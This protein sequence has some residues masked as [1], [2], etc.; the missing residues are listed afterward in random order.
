[1]NPLERAHEQIRQSGIRLGRSLHN[2]RLRRVRGL[3]ANRL[4]FLGYVNLFRM[5]PV[6]TVDEAL[7]YWTRQRDWQR[8]L[9]GDWKFDAGQYRAASERVV[10]CRYLRRFGFVEARAEQREWANA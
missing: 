10:F 1:M 3:A 8:R 9:R 6:T 2:E 7:E 4:Q 5:N